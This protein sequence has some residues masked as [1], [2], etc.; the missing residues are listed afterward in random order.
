MKSRILLKSILIITIVFC[1]ACSKNDDEEITAKSAEE[2]FIGTWK[3]IEFVIVCTSGSN[4]V[5]SFSICVQTGRL[6]INQNRT[7][8]ETSFYEFAEN[9]C[10]D[11]GV[12]NGTWRIV[13]DKLF[14]TESEF[15]ENEVT[16]FEISESTLRVGLYDTE[17]TCDGDIP[18]S[19]F[20]RELTRI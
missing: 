20:Y 8:S 3:P 1:T 15:G 19:H 18:S 5:E 2:L 7:W 9:M 13:N 10:E 4:E 16:F 6:T 11:D 14:V 17:F 12:D